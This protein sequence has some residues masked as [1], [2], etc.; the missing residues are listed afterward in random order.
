MKKTMLAVVAATAVTAAAQQA[1]DVRA[2]VFRVNGEPVRMAEINLAAQNLAS[3]LQMQGQQVDREQVTQ[4]AL[5]QVIDTEL[6]AQEARRRGLEA[7]TEAVGQVM[8]RFREQH[9]GAEALA[10]ELQSSGLDPE[11][12]ES[13][14]TESQ[15]VQSLIDEVRGTVTVSDE[16]IETF[17]ADNPDLFESPEQ[18]RARHILF[19]AGAEATDEE[20]QAARA[21]AEAARQRALGD[22]EFAEL[23]EELS[24]G[25]SAVQGGDLGFFTRDRMVEPFASAA[26]DLEPGEIS[27]VVGTEFGYHVIKLEERRPAGT[28]SLDDVRDRIRSSLEGQQVDAKVGELL[29]SLREKAEVVPVGP[30]AEAGPPTASA[31]SAEGAGGDGTTQEEGSR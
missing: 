30:A 23:A 2:V 8:Q 5:R 21:K 11:W 6:L 12:L 10:T 31:P 13:I 16:E 7:D 14:V 4:A 27:P 24:E 26:F 1:P 28:D 15:L 19:Q 18:V 9:G 3:Q 22:E 25:P 29:E 20:R 17:Y